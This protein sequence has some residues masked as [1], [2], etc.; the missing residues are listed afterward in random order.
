VRQV[1]DVVSGSLADFDAVMRLM[2]E[3]VAWL[4]A[5][6]RPGQWGTEPLSGQQKS[7]DHMRK[8]VGDNDL[9]LARIDG[10]IVGAMLLGDHP[11]YYVEPVAEPEIYLHLLVASRRHIG[12][13]I[14]RR[15]VDK[16]IA[17]AREEGIGLIRVDCYAGDDRKLVAA[18]ERLGFTPTTPFQ[19]ENWPGQLLELRLTDTMPD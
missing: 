6:G 4:A 2:D 3:A 1:I 19:V 7:V 5:A 13:G 12:A 9:W 8:E 18:Y 14:G 16:A 15:L 17:L 11:T 10:E